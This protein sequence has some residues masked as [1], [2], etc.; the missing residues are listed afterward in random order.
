MIALFNDGVDMALCFLTA[1]FNRAQTFSIMFRSGL[2]AGNYEE[3]MICIFDKAAFEYLETCGGAL[4][5]WNVVLKRRES[6]I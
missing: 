1:L 3:I 2:T 4:S 5:C 6:G